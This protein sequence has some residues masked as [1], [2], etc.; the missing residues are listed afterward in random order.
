MAFPL[1]PESGRRLRATTILGVRRDGAV[2]LAGDGQVTQGD[3]VVKHGARK[4]RTLYDGQV[5]A[6]FAGAVAD[7]LTLFTKFE[8]ELKAWDGNLRRASV[9]LA[10]EWRTDRYL[11]RL[12]AQLIVGDPD[13]LLVLSGEGD[14]IE[15]D[16]G[17]AAI[18]SG[19]PYAIAAA[20]ALLAHTPLDARAT[21]EA[22][23]TIAA[24][25]CIFTN[26]RISVESVGRVAGD[27]VAVEGDREADER[28][29]PIGGFVPPTDR[30]G[31][32]EDEDDDDGRAAAGE[33]EPGDDDDDDREDGE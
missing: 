26:H 18:G 28:E 30:G 27:G 17:V 29:L 3:V 32:E 10:K 5:L 24:D 8:A 33:R 16:D 25:I 1:Y 2:A 21:V 6:G 23:M 13:S 4:I 19:S 14:V 15:P 31:A 7:A 11:R 12:E 22:A 20:K 9:E